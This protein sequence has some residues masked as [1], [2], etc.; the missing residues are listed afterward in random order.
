MLVYVRISHE[1]QACA[2]EMAWEAPGLCPAIGISPTYLSPSRHLLIH[3][4]ESSRQVNSSSM[5]PLSNDCYELGAYFSM[6]VDFRAAT[7]VHR[8]RHTA[9]CLPSPQWRTNVIRLKEAW[10]ISHWS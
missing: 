5:P 6:Q 7:V 9:G 10:A 3:E 2:Q 8:S 1:D 4:V